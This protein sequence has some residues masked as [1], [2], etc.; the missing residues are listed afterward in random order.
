MSPQPE[1]HEAAGGTWEHDVG[2][3]A[4]CLC[5]HSRSIHDEGRG[6]CGGHFGVFVCRCPYFMARVPPTASDEG[7]DR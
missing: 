5:G 1:G 6:V 2:R 7:S 3:Q 4:L